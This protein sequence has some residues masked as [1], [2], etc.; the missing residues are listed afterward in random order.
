MLVF[1]NCYTFLADYS[2]KNFQI[3][4]KIVEA[5]AIDGIFYL[6]IVQY[7]ESSLMCAIETK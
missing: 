2:E 4:K 5:E 7:N 1:E 6:K 3:F